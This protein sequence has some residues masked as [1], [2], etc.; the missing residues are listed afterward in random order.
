M[1]DEIFVKSH[2][3]RDLLQSAGL[4]KNDRLVAPIPVKREEKE[5]T[6]TAAC[7]ACALSTIARLSRRSNDCLRRLALEMGGHV[8]RFRKNS[9]RSVE[10][11]WACNGAP[12]T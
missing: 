9:S 3:A 7:S 6:T 11:A 12:T 2:V 10:G 1:S 5:L 8:S 4:F